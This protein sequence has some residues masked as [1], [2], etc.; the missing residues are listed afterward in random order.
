MLCA[1]YMLGCAGASDGG[2]CARHRCHDGMV[3]RYSHAKGEAE[4]LLDFSDRNS[5][6]VYSLACCG[7]DMVNHEL[8]LHLLKSGIK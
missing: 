3:A 6:N 1:E 8:L 2:R 7:L 4:L 5:L